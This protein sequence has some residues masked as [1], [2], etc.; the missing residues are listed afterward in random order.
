MPVD[1][2]SG[3]NIGPEGAGRIHDYQLAEETNSAYHL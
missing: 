1:Q 2:G 3:V